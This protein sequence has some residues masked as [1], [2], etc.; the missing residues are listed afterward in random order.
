MRLL[1]A[2]ATPVAVTLGVGLLLGLVGPM[3][4][5]GGDPASVGV[6]TLFFRRLAVG[7]LCIPRGLLPALQN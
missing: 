4:G 6:S 2:R 1:R 7:R 5:R 3:A